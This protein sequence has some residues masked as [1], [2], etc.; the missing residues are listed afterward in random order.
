M[1][2]KFQLEEVVAQKVFEKFKL[3]SVE[4][5]KRFEQGMVN[6]VFSL[7]DEYVFKINTA[8]P[9]LP[10]LEK[11]F[12]VYEALAESNI[13]VPSAIA[14]DD[15]REIINYPYLIYKQI[16]GESLDTLWENLDQKTQ[17]ELLE[18]MGGVLDKIHH[19]RPKDVILPGEER[20]PGLKND[21][22]NR[23]NKVSDEL[24][25]SKV[26]D[27]EVIPRIKDFYLNNSL[28][29][30]DVNPSLLHGNYGFGNIIVENNRINGIIDWEW[31]SFGHSEEELAVLLYRVYKTDSQRKVFKEGYSKNQIISETFDKRYLP[32]VLLYYLKVLPEVPKWTHK[33]DKQKEYLGET[34]SLIKQIGL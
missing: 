29:D 27:A 32:Y 26:L 16:H 6:D 10:K 20:Y 19:L 3:G 5:I 33:P 24:L 21:I 34:K 14:L 28:F 9:D 22:S 11:E 12:A 30:G 13:P 4:N 25:E 23:I 15:S 31:A 18:Q 2:R 17:D 7:N 1:Y 8:H